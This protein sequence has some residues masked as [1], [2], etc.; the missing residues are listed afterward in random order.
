MTSEYA[1]LSVALGCVG[2]ACVT[3]GIQLIRLKKQLLVL[4]VSFLIEGELNKLKE[5]KVNG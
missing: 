4:E 5:R 3:L 2:I 1:V